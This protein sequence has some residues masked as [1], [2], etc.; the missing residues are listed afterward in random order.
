LGIA[1]GLQEQQVLLLMWL[2]GEDMNDFALPG[3]VLLS[4]VLV[5]GTVFIGGIFFIILCLFWNFVREV[6]V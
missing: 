3:I 1:Q 5:A 6:F 2:G 4:F